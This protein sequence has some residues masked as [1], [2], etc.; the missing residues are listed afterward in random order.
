DRGRTNPGDPRDLRR[1]A[2]TLS[3]EAES[4]PGS[5]RAADQSLGKPPSL[6]RSG[7]VFPLAGRHLQPR[8]HAIVCAGDRS[9]PRARSGAVLPLLSAARGGRVPRARARSTGT[10]AVTARAHQS[11]ACRM[12][13]ELDQRSPLIPAALF[14]RDLTPGLSRSFWSLYC[15]ALTPRP[16]SSARVPHLF[17][18]AAHGAARERPCRAAAAT[19][20]RDSAPA[21]PDRY[22]RA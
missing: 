1:A 8:L 14:L 19:P 10:V 5:G 22:R 20:A 16:F 17:G 18:D 15:R 13:E 2:A 6:A 21:T 7:S 11:C 12:A 3:R 9:R 4:H